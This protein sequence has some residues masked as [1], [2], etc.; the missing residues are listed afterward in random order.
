[1]GDRLTDIHFSLYS[2]PFEPGLECLPVRRGGHVLSEA[3]VF[4]N[5]L[6][7][8]RTDW[9]RDGVLNQLRYHR[10]GPPTRVSPVAPY[11]DNLV[12]RAEPVGAA[13]VRRRLGRP[14]STRW[15]PAPNGAS[16]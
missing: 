16:C 8:A 12:L 13:S 11:I 7:L 3:S 6:P 15:C 5:G 9:I 14:P 2:D 10:A 1:M 4:D